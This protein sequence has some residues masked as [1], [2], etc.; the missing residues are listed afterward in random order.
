MNR[1][2]MRTLL[3]ER[4]CDSTSAIWSDAR[5][6]Q[7]LNLS[8]REICR[9]L[10]KNGPINYQRTEYAV[11][12]TTADS[13]ADLPINVSDIE[14][15]IDL[16]GGPYELPGNQDTPQAI[17]RRAYDTRDG[18]DKAGATYY[19]LLYKPRTVA[20]FSKEFS[21]ETDRCSGWYLRLATAQG[22]SFTFSYNRTIDDIDDTDTSDDL[23]WP[24][25]PPVFHDDVIHHA[26]MTLLGYTASPTTGFA[27]ALAGG[28]LETAKG[29]TRERNTPLR[30]GRGD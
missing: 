8:A 27:G 5:L 28:G 15:P 7:Q 23:W 4:V 17:L 22:G 25:I 11:A 14:T 3:R 1:G 13:V 16:V 6:N 30:T 19:A 18:I 26:A 24:E 9:T 10:S 12:T 21:D 20:H 2:Q 29:I